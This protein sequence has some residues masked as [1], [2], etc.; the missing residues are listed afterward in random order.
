MMKRRE[1]MTEKKRT[2]RWLAVLLALAYILLTA[3]LRE[4]RIRRISGRR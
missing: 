1:N 4:K 3:F 2:M